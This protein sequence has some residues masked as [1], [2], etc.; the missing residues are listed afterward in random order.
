M[1]DNTV[2]LGIITAIVVL[3][4][5]EWEKYQAANP[6]KKRRKKTK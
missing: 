4:L 2:G 5:R 6:P 1:D 3:S